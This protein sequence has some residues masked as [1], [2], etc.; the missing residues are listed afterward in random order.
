MVLGKAFSSA[1]ASFEVRA[2]VSRNREIVPL[3]LAL[4]AVLLGFVPLQP[5]NL[6]QIGRTAALTVASP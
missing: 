1:G 4:C 3:A 6:L 5:S 2:P